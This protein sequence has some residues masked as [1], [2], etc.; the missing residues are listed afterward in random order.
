M[1][2]KSARPSRRWL[3][4]VSLAVVVAAA[5]W[6]AV[7]G[8]AGG[9][10]QWTQQDFR[11]R[12]VSAHLGAS[13]GSYV[14][15][16]G[17]MTQQ[18]RTAGLTPLAE[19][20]ATLAIHCHPAA[21]PT[22]HETLAGSYSSRIGAPEFIVWGPIQFSRPDAGTI[23]WTTGFTFAPPTPTGTADADSWAWCNVNG[24]AS[25]EQILES[26][27]V[28]GATGVT[29]LSVPWSSPMPGTSLYS[30]TVPG[31]DSTQRFNPNDGTPY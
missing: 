15:L 5:A 24:G 18:A 10:S 11:L 20:N 12:A 25:G 19:L 17:T 23:K 31:G 6:S 26:I 22:D 8:A 30:Y 3:G 29:W 4:A 16:S 13:Q 21:D 2:G 9:N 1:H 28:T 7:A 14:T 27:D